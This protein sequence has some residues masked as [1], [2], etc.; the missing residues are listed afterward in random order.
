MKVYIIT[1]TKEKPSTTNLCLSQNW[2]GNE[3]QKSEQNCVGISTTNIHLHQYRIQSHLYK[4]ADYEWQ[5]IK[6]HTKEK[7]SKTSNI[8]FAILPS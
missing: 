7:P 6:T 4:N 3:S 8:T 5:Y 2:K 1:H